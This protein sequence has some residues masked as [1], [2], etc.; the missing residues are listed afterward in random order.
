VKN[1]GKV[2]EALL[3]ENDPDVKLKSTVRNSFPSGYKPELDVTPELN[4]HLDSHY[5]QLMGILHCA[6]ELS[7]VDMFGEV[8]QLSQ[9]QAL[10]RQGNLEAGRLRDNPKAI[11]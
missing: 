4:D 1:S 6:I 2:V 8:S 7:Q 11:R 9:L 3:H 10:P 5:L